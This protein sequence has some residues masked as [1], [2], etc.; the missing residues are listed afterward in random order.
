M[1]IIPIH[2]ENHWT[3]AAINFSK[4]RFE[5]YDCLQNGID[6]IENNNDA[7][8]ISRNL[9]NS[10]VKKFDRD[11]YESYISG[12]DQNLSDEYSFNNESD[13]CEYVINILKRWM[14]DEAN[15]K[16]KLNVDCNGSVKDEKISNSEMNLF[17]LETWTVYSPRPPIMPPQH[18]HYDCGVFVMLGIDCLTRNIILNS[19]SQ[20]DIDYARDLL[21]QVETLWN[22]LPV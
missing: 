2:L 16:V 15:D 5:Y 9:S 10:F 18:N 21:I 3:F 1:I 20:E 6:K 13:G 22:H 14:I 4:K 12:D 8:S 17:L 11:E 7:S 19:F